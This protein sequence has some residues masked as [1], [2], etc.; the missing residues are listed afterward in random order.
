MNRCTFFVWIVC[1]YGVTSEQDCCV[2]W[3]DEA[4][5]AGGMILKAVEISGLSNFTL[6]QRKWKSY[7]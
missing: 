2:P 1:K 7:S 5:P 6:A 3:S 4:D